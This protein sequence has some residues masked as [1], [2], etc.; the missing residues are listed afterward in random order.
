MVIS[1]QSV[2]QILPYSTSKEDS[3]AGDSA[4]CDFGSVVE[5][6]ILEDGTVL[7]AGHPLSM[8][9]QDLDFESCGF[10]RGI[11]GYK[12]PASCLVAFSIKIVVLLKQ[13]KNNNND[14]IR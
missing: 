14:Y 3:E 8:M 7:V 13:E 1:L 11:D 6:V 12:P 9:N 10:V 2:E 5:Q 4:I